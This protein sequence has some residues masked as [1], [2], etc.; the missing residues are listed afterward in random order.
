MLNFKGM[1]FPAEVILVCI[2]V[3]RGLFVKH[4]QSG[5]NDGGA[6]SIGR[7]FDGE[8]VDNSFPALAGKSISP[9]QAPGGRKLADG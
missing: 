1:R 7:S 8:S 6:W 9:I 4:S 2:R 3:V 5:G